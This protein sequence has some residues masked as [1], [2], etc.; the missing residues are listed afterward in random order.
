MG[1]KKDFGT[2]SR[3]GRLGP[4]RPSRHSPS[5]LPLTG[6]PHPAPSPSS[7]YSHARPHASACARAWPDRPRPLDCAR[8]LASPRRKP[9][10]PVLPL[11]PLPLSPSMEVTAA[12]ITGHRPLP[13]WLFLSLSPSIKQ[14]STELSPLLPRSPSPSPCLPYSL[15]LG[16]RRRRHARA[17]APALSR[18]H[19]LVSVASGPSALVPRRRPLPARRRSSTPFV[20]RRTAQ[21]QELE[22]EDNLNFI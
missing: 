18:P 3:T 13:P 5:F 19:A 14:A 11:P 1:Y 9:L 10:P 4:Y 21:T 15:S 2:P 22:V 12:A 20:R 16:H 6:G 17:P 7:S 8:Y